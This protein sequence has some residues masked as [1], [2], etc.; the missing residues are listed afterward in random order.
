[1]PG[2][3]SGSSRPGN[4]LGFPKQAR[5]IRAFEFQQVRQQG[6]PVHGRLMTLGV[7]KGGEASEPRIG[8]ITSR[9]VGNAVTRNK[10]RR[11]LREI[12]RK[13]RPSMIKG[14]WLVVVAK[15]SAAKA[16]QQKLSDEWHQ[17]AQRGSILQEAMP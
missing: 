3:L 9:R 11:R 6:H 8:L 1:M 4:K 2:F 12:I 7:L 13:A 14:L 10:V 17:L 16:T 5:L 15:S